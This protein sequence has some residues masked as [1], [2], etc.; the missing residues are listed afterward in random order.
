MD[1]IDL[2]KT[3]KHLYAPSAKEWI[4]IDVPPMQFLMVDGKGSPGEALEYSIAVEWLF[5]VSYPVKFMSKRELDRDYAVMPLEGIWFA[6]DF[7][8]FTQPGRRDE[9]RWKLMILQPEWITQ[10]M[11]DL[12]I[13]K[14]LAK[15]DDRDYP[16]FCALTW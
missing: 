1:K 5:S 14:T 4:A 12:A 6:D 9:W 2:R 7:S 3:L 13:E 10:D 15:R 11:I 16:E 8:A